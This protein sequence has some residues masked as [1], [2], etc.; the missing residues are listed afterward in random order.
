[1]GRTA[2]IIAACFAVVAIRAAAATGAHATERWRDDCLASLDT[3]TEER[4]TTTTVAGHRDA[5]RFEID[6]ANGKTKLP[7]CAM[8]FAYCNPRVLSQSHL[9]N[10]QTGAWTPVTTEKLGSES[11]IVRG[12][13]LPAAH[14]RMRTPKNQIELWYSDSDEWL[15]M[16]TTTSGG[17][18]LS[19]RLR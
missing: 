19:Y 8:T 9:I 3:K 18:T 10:T 17:H 1:M 7:A 16:R 12:Q 2:P 6:G 4:G 5:D 11:I 13:S 14:Y 15:A